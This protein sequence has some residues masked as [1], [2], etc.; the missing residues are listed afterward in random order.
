MEDVCQLP[1]EV[2]GELRHCGSCDAPLA[3]VSTG[4]KGDWFCPEVNINVFKL[5]SK[6]ILVAFC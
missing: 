1:M 4:E 2:L 5:R 3:L 6:E